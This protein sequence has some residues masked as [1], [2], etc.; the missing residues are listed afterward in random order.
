M[1]HGNTLK[2]KQKWHFSQLGYLFSKIPDHCHVSTLSLMIN[3]SCSFM[4]I[5]YNFTLKIRK[6]IRSYWPA[7]F[8]FFGIVFWW[9]S[10]I[11]SFKTL[12][13]CKLWVFTRNILRLRDWS[14]DIVVIPR[15]YEPIKLRHLWRFPCNTYSYNSIIIFKVKARHWSEFITWY[16]LTGQIWANT[17]GPISQPPKRE[18]RLLYFSLKLIENDRE[19]NL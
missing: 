4:R 2:S 13:F 3:F 12:I 9:L 11:C 10:L 18:T 5:N 14:H 1:L 19:F 8:L 7:F 15:H 17:T 16:S 6:T